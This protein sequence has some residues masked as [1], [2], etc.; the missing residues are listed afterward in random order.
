MFE[1]YKRYKELENTRI[2]LK[3]ELD[4]VL[5]QLDK[6]KNDLTDF[7]K[8]VAFGQ[9]KLPALFDYIATNN[10]TITK[11]KTYIENSETPNG[12]YHDFKVREIKLSNGTV[13]R[14]RITFAG[15]YDWLLQNRDLESLVNE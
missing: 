6:T 12:G 13:W 8:A 1:N 5:E 3:L 10:L 2:E 9:L 14:E 11:Y 15:G 4:K 7:E